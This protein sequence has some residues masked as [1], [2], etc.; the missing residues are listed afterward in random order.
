MSA[1]P[2]SFILGVDIGTSK[3]AAVVARQVR[4]L[5]NDTLEI[6]GIGKAANKD[7][8][9]K[10]NIRNLTKTKEAIAQAVNEATSRASINYANLDALFANVNIGGT[11][12]EARSET[13]SI[14][15][16][17]PG[18]EVQ[19]NDVKQLF[20]DV[21]QT[22]TT[23]NNEIIHLLPLRFSV[24]D[25]A[26][27]YDP[28]GHIGLKLSGDFNVI[29][30]KK[31]AIKQIKQSLREA[32]S[33]LQDDNLMVSP[34][35]SAMSVLDDN[36]KRLGVVMVDIGAG[37]TDV[38]IYYD[39]L[40][41]HLAILPYGGNLLTSD[42]SEGCYLTIESAE[43]AKITL[44]ATNPDECGLNMLLVVPTAD[45]IPPIEVVAKNVALI[46]RARL[47][48]I[49]ALVYAEIKKSGYEQKLRAG[50]VLTGG[51]VQIKG[52]EGIFKDITKMHVQ[53]GAPK[54][55]ETTALYDQVMR[56]HSY[57]TALGLVWSNIKALDQRVGF[58][59]DLNTP[60]E[61]EETDAKPTKLKKTENN[62]FSF[63]SL[64]GTIG[65]FLNDD[66][67]GQDTY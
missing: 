44:S 21:Y 26:Q 63:R 40:L 39:G 11:L 58:D 66:I 22:S 57:A 54:G 17:S 12:V 10:G 47:R 2:D 42:I 43:E 45:G 41:R 48:E 38:V 16:K 46:A 7:G 64:K 52:I 50:I 25:E 49:A 13:G 20:R 32:N 15:C 18:S 53:V 1:T 36:H 55:L 60:Q 4:N 6:I 9:T 28:V 51:T 34:L 61:E 29:S 67:K 14:T 59:N 19:R 3:V 33:L 65:G 27:I 5:G 24:G 31:T 35:A 37:T 62:W 23:E 30:V 56:D 8:V